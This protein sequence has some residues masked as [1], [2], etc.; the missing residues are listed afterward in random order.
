MQTTIPTYYMSATFSTPYFFGVG[1]EVGLD[2]GVDY[3]SC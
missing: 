1:S 3:Q 2:G